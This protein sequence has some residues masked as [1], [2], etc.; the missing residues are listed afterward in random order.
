MM[1]M[2]WTS[3][4]RKSVRTPMI[5]LPTRLRVADLDACARIGIRAVQD[6]DH[7]VAAVDGLDEHAVKLP[8]EVGLALQVVVAVLRKEDPRGRQPP[9]YLRG[10]VFVEAPLG[11]RKQRPGKV[12]VHGRQQKLSMGERLRSKRTPAVTYRQP[13]MAGG[14][15]SSA[16]PSP[17]P[18]LKAY[19]LK[20]TLPRG[21][22]QHLRPRAPRPLRRPRRG[23]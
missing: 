14:W 17:P 12:D 3:P 2:P 7:R 18:R 13:G 22:C 8:G 5:G 21:A 19:G 11:E 6:G 9:P 4:S 10:K 15:A 20:F 1:L 23:E 16:R